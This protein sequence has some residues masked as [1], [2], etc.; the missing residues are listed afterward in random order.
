MD[1][2]TFLPGLSATAA[3]VE[4]AVAADRRGLPAARIAPKQQSI[5]FILV[6]GCTALLDALTLY[7][8]TSTFGWS[9]FSAAAVGF[10]LG[11][12]TNYLLSIRW[13]FVPGKFR[14]EI[15][16]SFFIATSL[17]GLVLNQLTMWFFVSVPRIH[18]LYAKAF[19]IVIVTVWNFA[20]KKRLVFIN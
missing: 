8:L 16:F 4:V 3:A 20:S 7:L 6:G 19:A 10:M 5:R 18:Y 14:R 13:V 11:S 17:I 12:T 2:P 15:E 9:Y 1:E